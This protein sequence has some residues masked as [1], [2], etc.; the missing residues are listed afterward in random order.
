MALMCAS[1]EIYNNITIGIIIS[2]QIFLWKGGPQLCTRME[3]TR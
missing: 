3:C 2:L 1:I